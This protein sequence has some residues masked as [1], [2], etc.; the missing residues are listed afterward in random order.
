MEQFDSADESVK[1]EILAKC[2]PLCVPFRSTGGVLLEE[3]V[4]HFSNAVSIRPSEGRPTV[5]HATFFASTSQIGSVFIL[6]AATLTDAIEI[7][8]L[9]P[10]AQ[11]GEEFGFGIEIR[12]LQ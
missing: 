12:P 6:D 1:T 5:S 9:H 10:A 8:S 11:L 2:G 3:G 4:E 7:A